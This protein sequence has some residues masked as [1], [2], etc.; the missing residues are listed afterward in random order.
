MFGIRNA[1]SCRAVAQSS[2]LPYRRVSL[3]RISRRTCATSAAI[4]RLAL[5]RASLL[6]LLACWTISSPRPCRASVISNVVP[7]NVTPTS[8]SVLW[9]TAPSTPSIAIFS[10]PGGLTN[11]AG[12]FGIETFPLHTGDPDV[13]SGYPRRQTQAAIRQRTL[14]FGQ[15][16]VRVDGCQPG[17]TY[18]YKLTSAFA[19]SNSVSYPASGPLPSITTAVENT[20]VV[21]DQQLVLDV[22]G[23]TLGEIVVVS[24][25]TAAYPL[26]AVVGD[27][28][29]TNQAFF[30]LND[31]FTLAGG[32]NFGPLGQQQF[33]ADVLGTNQTDT[34]AQFTLTF[35]NTLA[36]AQL[37]E[38]SVS[39]PAFVSLTLGS[40]SLQA[41]QTGSVS[42]VVSSTGV[43]N[44]NFV[45]SLPDTSLTNFTLQGLAS[46]L[47]PVASLVTPQSGNRYAFTL[48]ARSG[49]VILGP[50][51]IGQ[52]GFTAAANSPSGAIPLTFQQL[53]A[54]TAAGVPV[55]NLFGGAGQ[56]V[57]VGSQPLVQASLGLNQ[58]R[59]LTLY[60]KPNAN[61]FIQYATNLNPPV[62][63]YNA[64]PVGLTNFVATI[65]LAS[66]GPDIIFYRAVQ[67][68][69]DPPVLES[70]L[71]PDQS[72]SLLVFGVPTNQYTVEYK[73]S[74][75]SAATW[76]AL[77]TTTLTNPFTYVT[78]PGTNPII[79]YR[80]RKN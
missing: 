80:L 51:Q 32:T 37:T 31:L 30:N 29:G 22:P 5:L 11:L 38:S 6:I 2:T 54:R 52:I 71:N 35:T 33:A 49:Q 14:R 76:S 20:F 3:C 59:I 60:G 45:L 73:T 4:V 53:S 47:D 18:Y 8:F 17:T 57:I 68:T 15:M 64:F 16:L 12:Q 19:L 50:A 1:E 26:A 78:V 36:I 58:A 46:E 28:V 44:V 9:R 43:T 62:V 48:A 39:V 77:L 66:V 61:Y 41:G 55:V 13:A 7:V 23:D 70:L 63:W 74:L 42:V 40:T 10:D 75:S 34:L 79:F 72:R 25:T 24:N 65:P 21:D 67:F 27:G 56:V 69:A